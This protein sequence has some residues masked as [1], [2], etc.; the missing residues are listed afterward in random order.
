MSSLQIPGGS[1]CDFLRW[2]LVLN[3]TNTKSGSFQIDVSYGESKPNTNGF[4]GGG[5]NIRMKG[6]YIVSERVHERVHQKVFQ[7]TD[8]NFQ[9]PI[10]LIQMDDN[11]L[12]FTDNQSKL[13]LGNAGWGYVLNRIK[14][15]Q[16]N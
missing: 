6:I 14:L 3:T 13:L 2:N 5:K 9:A 4:I 10:F 1:K 7:L 12:H 11:I 15:I 16:T 8:K